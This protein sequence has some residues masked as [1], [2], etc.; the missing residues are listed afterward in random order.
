MDYR[1]LGRSGLRVSP[2]CLGTM[3]FGARTEEADA[4]AIV[5]DARERGINF[6]DTAD[7]YAGG[8]SEQIVGRAI[9]TDRDHWIV[10]T[11]VANPIGDGPNQR[12]LSRRRLFQACDESLQRM[13]QRYHSQAERE[14]ERM[15]QERGS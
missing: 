6:I 9:A 1:K 15:A 5:A 3:T 14:W 8:L 7:A 10:A 2:L 13:M 4:R 11:K 12:G